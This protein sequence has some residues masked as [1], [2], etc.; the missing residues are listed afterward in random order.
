[1]SSPAQ[2]HAATRHERQPFRKV[3]AAFQTAWALGR[4]PFLHEYLTHGAPQGLPVSRDGRTDHEG[5]CSKTNSM[6]RRHRPCMPFFILAISCPHLNIDARASACCHRIGT[7]QLTA[8]GHS[9]K[10][11]EAFH[12]VLLESQ[13]PFLFR[14]NKHPLLQVKMTE[15]PC[16][17][18]QTCQLDR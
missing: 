8:E 3:S 12:Y 14:L 16:K 18:E 11:P 10:T 7:V 9:V 17:G 5:L 4:C 13:V 1:M 6:L 15:G 2:E